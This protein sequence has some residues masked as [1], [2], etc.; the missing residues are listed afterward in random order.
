[1][2]TQEDDTEEEG[3]SM[4]ESSSDVDA[5]NEDAGEESL[6][7]L[8]LTSQELEGPSVSELTGVDPL[9]GEAEHRAKG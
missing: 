9:T 5:D 2:V 8:P 4:S 6:Q 7:M 1:M 3:S